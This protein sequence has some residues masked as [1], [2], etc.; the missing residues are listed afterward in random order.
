MTTVFLPCQ[1][2]VERLL[3]GWASHILTSGRSAATAWTRWYA[4]CLFKAA[5]LCEHEVIVLRIWIELLAD[6]VDRF[7][8]RLYVWLK[9][10]FALD[11]SCGYLRCLGDGG[12]RF[13]VATGAENFSFNSLFLCTHLL[14]LFLTEQILLHTRCRL[15][16]I[17]M[18]HLIFFDPSI[19]LRSESGIFLH[20]TFLFSFLLCQVELYKIIKRKQWVDDTY[21]IIFDF[22]NSLLFQPCLAYGA[23]PLHRLGNAFAFAVQLLLTSSFAANSA[24]TASFTIE[25]RANYQSWF[26][27]FTS[28]Q[29]WKIAQVIPL[30]PPTLLYFTSLV[31]LL[32]FFLVWI[33]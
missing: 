33:Y 2:G 20:L 26:L 23:L 12:S 13:P 1:R 25:L 16:H 24:F 30:L 28:C 17:E 15:T 14:S 21:F 10:A 3:S 5:N 22:P 32:A 29:K 31:H 8:E 4:Q 11:W 7:G 9:V 19:N 6:G 18:V 27:S